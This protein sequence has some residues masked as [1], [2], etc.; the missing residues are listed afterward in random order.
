MESYSWTHLPSL[1]QWLLRRNLYT[2]CITGVC[3]AAAIALAAGMARM[4]VTCGPKRPLCKHMQ[5]HVRV[6]VARKSGWAFLGQYDF[7]CVCVCVWQVR[8]T[9]RE[10]ILRRLVLVPKYQGKAQYHKSCRD[11]IA[12]ALKISFFSALVCA[13][14]HAFFWESKLFFP[15]GV[16][17]T[18]YS[19]KS[20]DL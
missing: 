16:L 8:N 7:R 3:A 4:A 6:F 17:L 13:C 20:T 14:P 12:P 2:H 18:R 1:W 10:S 19:L 9:I 15:D 11:H 5:P